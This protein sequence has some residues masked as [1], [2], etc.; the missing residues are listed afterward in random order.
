[1]L[2]L[3]KAFKSPAPHL[4][5]LPMPKAKINCIGEIRNAP[6]RQNPQERAF[7]VYDVSNVTKNGGLY[8]IRVDYESDPLKVFLSEARQITGQLPDKG[9]ERYPVYS[10]AEVDKTEYPILKN[11]NL[12]RAF[13]SRFQRA[14]KGRPLAF[15]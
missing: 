5:L 1:M 2:A 4:R 6:E 14:F 9:G 12:Y 13:V 15:V 8:A 3:V 10:D 11:T 7:G